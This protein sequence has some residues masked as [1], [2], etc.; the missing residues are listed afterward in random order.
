[1]SESMPSMHSMPPSAHA[2]LTAANEAPG[3]ASATDQTKA[4]AA[5][6]A[7]A[8][9][10]VDINFVSQPNAPKLGENQFEV[11]VKGSDG[12]PISNADVSIL[13]V[14]PAMPQMKMPE[15]RNAV[16]LKPASARKY[17]GSGQVM[18]AGRWN[19]TISISGRA[20]KSG[21]RK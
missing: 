18:M 3:V 1:M 13:F 11:A 21:R 5:R 9:A 4:A 7:P 20:R 16:K 17:T 8:A 12:K 19:V 6:P 2:S 15:M 14:M 10:R